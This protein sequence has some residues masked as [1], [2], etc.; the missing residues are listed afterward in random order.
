L[1]LTTSVASHSCAPV[2]LRSMT[3]RSVFVIYF[4]CL[5]K[6]SNKE[7]TADF[8]AE[9]CLCWI[10]LLPKSA[11]RQFPLSNT[12]SWTWC[13]TVWIVSVVHPMPSGFP[14]RSM[15]AFSVEEYNPNG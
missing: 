4:L 8:D 13:K 1:L 9:T 14:Q 11:L 12:L 6:E 15:K 10:F 3:A 7:S 5:C 2:P